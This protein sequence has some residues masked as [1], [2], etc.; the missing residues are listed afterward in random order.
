MSAKSRRPGTASSQT[1]NECVQV[2]VRC[3]PMSNRERSEGSP[4]VVNVY[5]N[6]G[7]VE[8][9]NVVDANKEQRK[10]FT[11]DAA[12]DASASQTTL[13]HEVVFPLVSSVLEGFNGCIFAY[14]Q[15]GTGKTF[16]MEGVRGNDDLMGII[17]RTFEQIWLHINRTE[18]FQFLVDVSYLEIYMEELRDLLKPNSKHLEVRERGSGVY[19]PNLHAINCKSVDDMIR[20]MKVGNK[21][22]TVGFTNMNEH[23]SRSHAIFMIKIEMCDTETNTI[24]V[25]KL[26][27]IDLAGSERQSKTGASAER[28]KEASK[29]NLALSSLGNV[30]SALAESSPHVPY[31][32]SKLTRLL[33]DSLGGNSKT[34]MI[35]NIGPSNY[36]YNETL[37]TLRYASRAKSI[38]NQPI[39]NEDPQDA[40]L[41]EY[42]EE[43][44][45]LKRLIAPQQQQRSE[46]Q[47]T[48]KKQ[49]VKKPKKEPISQEL[50]GS[51]LQASSAD[52]QVDEDRDSDGDGAESESDKENEA[53]VA[54]SN[55]ELE[56]E[57]V[58]NAK[59]AA[60]LA[61]L[62]GQLVRGGK[63]LLDTYSERQIELEKKLVEIAERKKREIEIQQQLELQEE[64]TLEIR[65]R[66]VSLEQEV[67]LK[68]RKLSKCYAKYLALQQELNDCKHDH[69]QD[70]RE[71]EMAQNELV[72][73]LKRQLLIIDNFVPIEVKQRLYTQAKYDEEQEEWKFSSFPLPLP[74]SG[75]D[76]RQGYRRPVSHPQRRRP[77][78]EHAL[79]E[80]K[81]N[82]P[83]SLRF[84]SENIVSYEL[85]MPCRTT[86]EYRTPKVSASLQAVLAQ[87]M[88]T[89]GDDIDIVDSHTNSLRS[90]LENIIN[91][92]SS[93]NGGPGS[94]A[95][96]LAANTAGSG[97]G[98]MPNVR[99]IKSSRGLPSAGTAL[100]SNRRPPTGRIPAKKPASAYPKARGLV[101]K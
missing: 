45:R 91:A 21:N 25:G 90:R 84:K 96:P 38:Q 47:G 12:Y 75:G 28:L 29:I 50:I 95:G 78:S 30:I 14:G 13:Y 16:T 100:D 53:E 55:E 99:N 56:R 43:I 36:N 35:A 23:S 11:Y 76:G 93:S 40:K 60:K 79:Q 71:L 61:E 74:P 70:L 65:E 80:A 1:P 33:Q 31:R 37:T 6:R 10:V 86:Q 2:V 26:N 83:S 85:E 69:N 66:N 67:E 27:L 24:K 68:K 19:V 94:G 15:T 48:I 57:R 64:T 3:R 9:Q 49:R 20:V 98:S 63:N 7:V 17:P 22:R 8:L 51:A 81:S 88:Q 54:K 34:I 82:A 4:E 62:E 72:K 44:E 101:N 89:G 41:K 73:E 32:D 92:N 77:T 46:K 59:L 97:V 42:Q 5:P 87:A 58:E 39:K 18:N 52:L